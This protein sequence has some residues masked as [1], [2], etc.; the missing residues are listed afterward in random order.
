MIPALTCTKRGL[1]K[2][3]S[4]RKFFLD[5]AERKKSFPQWQGL[6]QWFSNFSVSKIHLVGG[7]GEVFKMQIPGPHSQS[8]ILLVLCGAAEPAFL[9]PPMTQMQVVIHENVVDFHTETLTSFTVD[10][11]L[12]LTVFS[13]PHFPTRMFLIKGE[14]RTN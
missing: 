13:T 3:Q 1:C 4:K 5:F 6:G 7:E 2:P 11:R 10:I 14:M 12:T 9:K 8:L